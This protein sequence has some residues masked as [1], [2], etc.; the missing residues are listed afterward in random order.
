MRLPAAVLDDAALP[1]DLG[2]RHALPVDRHLRDPAGDAK[3]GAPPVRET[4][5]FPYRASAP[6]PARHVSLARELA[7]LRL[8]IKATVFPA[9][10]LTRFRTAVSTLDVCLTIRYFVWREAFHLAS[11][12]YLA[13]YL[14]LVMG[15]QGPVLQSIPELVGKLNSVN[16]FAIQTGIMCLSWLALQ[17]R[18]RTVMGCDVQL[19]SCQSLAAS[20]VCR[21]R[22][23]PASFI[24]LAMR[25]APQLSVLAICSPF[26]W[27]G[28]VA[29]VCAGDNDPLRSLPGRPAVNVPALPRVSLQGRLRGG[30]GRGPDGA[31]SDAA[32]VHWPIPRRAAAPR[33]RAAACTQRDPRWAQLNVPV[34]V[35]AI[36]V[37]DELRC[38]MRRR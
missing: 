5:P 37:H 31:G 7:N 30:R 1:L 8:Y 13:I 3:A 29:V 19:C 2:R 20:I 6:P 36:R 4:F 10:M 14:Q 9:L 16:Q 33:V 34:G 18:V 17:K 27:A 35:S 12:A 32:A 15:P 21:S 26:C 38:A 23:V 11:W 28:A 22:R 24:A 25:H